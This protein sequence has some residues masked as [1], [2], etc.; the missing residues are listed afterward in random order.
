MRDKAQILIANKIDELLSI[1][2]AKYNAI[3]G[4]DTMIKQGLEKLKQFPDRWY[5]RNPEQ[6]VVDYINRE[7]NLNVHLEPYHENCGF[8]EIHGTDAFVPADIQYPWEI[9]QEEFDFVL[10][11]W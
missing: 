10:N 8:G 5:V 9:T 3:E 7:H 1:R 11:L 6:R 4:I 2:E